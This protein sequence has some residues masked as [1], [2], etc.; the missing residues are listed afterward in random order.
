[1]KFNK[2]T[3]AFLISTGAIALIGCGGDSGGDSANEDL[4]NDDADEL[5]LEDTEQALEVYTDLSWSVGSDELVGLTYPTS[6]EN[7]SLIALKR[8]TGADESVSHTLLVADASSKE[9]TTPAGISLTRD[10]YRDVLALP[11][12]GTYEDE[13]FNSVLIATC[14]Y[15]EAGILEGG[16]LT[17]GIDEPMGAAALVAIEEPPAEAIE[18]VAAA[19]IEIFVPGTSITASVDIE[20]ISEES[21]LINCNSLGGLYVA[22]LASKGQSVYGIGFWISG[23]RDAGDTAIFEVEL[24]YNYAENE[25]TVAEFYEVDHDR[26]GLTAIAEDAEDDFLVTMNVEGD[27]YLLD[28]LNEGGI[29]LQNEGNPFTG[30]TEEGAD[31][32]DI[33]F[34]GENLFAVSAD[35]GLA[36]ADFN[37]GDFIMLTGAD[38]ENC[39]D[40]LAVSGSTL[41]C[42]DSTDEGKLIEFTAPAV[43]QS[44][45]D[46]PLIVTAAAHR[47]GSKEEAEQIKAELEGA[48]AEVEVK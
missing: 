10:Y 8:S 45:S 6:A 36:G 37:G 21:Y 27:T 35:A 24:A 31:I 41:W 3:L 17:S 7:A 44:V 11:L 20:D 40:Q 42:H 12:S 19:T 22:D 1:M 25:V 29:Q 13:A 23:K 46:E 30:D 2:L 32:L 5:P 15:T 26:L 47:S 33:V 39:V 18:S 14:G 43:P 16:T 28:E 34:S 9:F 4:I 48:G 38:Y